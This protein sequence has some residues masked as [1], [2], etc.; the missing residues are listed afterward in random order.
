MAGDDVQRRKNEH[1]DLCLEAPVESPPDLSLFGAVNLL[2]DALPELDLDQIDLSARVLGRTLKAPL[3][4]TGMT[5]GTDRARAVNRDLAR[6]AEA[7]GVAF[8]VGSQR[9]MALRPETAST[10]QVRD[11]APDVLLFGNL[12]AQQI[13]ELGVPAVVQLVERLEA[14]AIFI[15]LNPAQ[16]LV[17]PEGDRRFSGCLDAIRRV[18]DVLGERVWVKETGCGLSRQVAQRLVSAGVGGLDV[19]GMGGTSWIRV[20]A[21]RGGERARELG[22]ELSGWGIPTAAAVAAVADLGVPVVASGGLRSASDAVKALSLGADLAGF[23]LPML[24]AQA[25]GG[26]PAVRAKLDGLAHSMRALMLLTG[27]RDAATLRTRPRVLTGTL[28]AWI[29]SLRGDA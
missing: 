12:G 20:E 3:V 24:R 2:H 5:G 16:E 28:P 27:S 29:A 11:A 23:A 1:L 15:H 10:W 25:E 13:V 19:S 26:E 7:C 9:G 17:Q 21:L 8:G 6:A 22:E 14:D 4:V 18:V